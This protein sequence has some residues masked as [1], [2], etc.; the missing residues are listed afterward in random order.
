[1]PSERLE[2]LNAATAIP[3]NRIRGSVPQ[4]LHPDQLLPEGAA[5][6]ETDGAEVSTNGYSAA[7]SAMKLMHQ[8]LTDIDDAVEAAKITRPIPNQVVAPGNK[9]MLERVVDPTHAQEI[10]GAMAQSA[11]RVARGVERHL[12]ALEQS[13]GTVEQAIEGKVRNPRA[14]ATESAD[15]RRYVY[16]LKPDVRTGWLESRILD[17]DL[18]VAHAVL[19]FSPWASGLQPKR[20]ELLR[21]M[22]LQR[23]APT[24]VRMRDGLRSAQKKVTTAM[25]TF[26]A[27][28][29]RR[30]PPLPS[31]RVASAVKALKAGGDR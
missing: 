24:E 26:S 4:S 22:A 20:A 25:A 2:R 10:R 3:A 30:L 8:S 14:D 1:M 5:C 28:Y 31:D 19:N 16:D 15:I 21:E 29:A 6:V 7:R 9:P 23:F 13:L 27:E 11:D 17:G 18:V 12:K